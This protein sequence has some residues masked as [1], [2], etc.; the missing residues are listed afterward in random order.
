MTPRVRLCDVLKA[1]GA[2]EP[3]LNWIGEGR[4]DTFRETW[5]ECAKEGMR[6]WLMWLHDMTLVDC[7][8]DY[9]SSGG[10]GSP[11]KGWYD[12]TQTRRELGMATRPRYRVLTPTPELLSARPDIQ[13]VLLAYAAEHGIAPR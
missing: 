5:E 12:L 9:C 8:T 11:S 7:P 4:H 6:G 10:P 2:C 3:A 13:R 1:I